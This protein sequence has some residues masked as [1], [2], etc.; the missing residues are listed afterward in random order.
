[1]GQSLVESDAN[2][3]AIVIAGLQRLE[4][5]LIDRIAGS[6]HDQLRIQRHQLRNHGFD[7]VEPLLRSEPS[8]HSQK[9]SVRLRQLEL[10][11]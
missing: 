9:R 10:A 5:G 6:Q 3:H 2:P 11:L 4:R 8:D 7:E 1:M